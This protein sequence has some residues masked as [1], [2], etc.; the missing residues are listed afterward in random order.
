MP[1]H[2]LREH[3]LMEF[4]TIQPHFAINS[5]ISLRNLII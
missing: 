4:L 2:L 5:N 1:V 3:N